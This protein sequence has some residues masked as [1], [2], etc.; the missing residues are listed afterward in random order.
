MR[1]CVLAGFLRF[2]QLLARHPWGSRPLV[3]DPER[4]LTPT[5]RSEL[6]RRFDERRAAGAGPA[7][8]EPLPAMYICTPRDPASSHWC[9]R[10]ARVW[11]CACGLV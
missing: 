6:Q 3:V 4:V 9:V 8:G 10:C 11:G 5:Q 2:L 7:G 1:V